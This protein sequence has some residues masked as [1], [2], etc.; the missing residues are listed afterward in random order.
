MPLP[1][2]KQSVCEERARA[3]MSP[4]LNS[5]NSS[6]FGMRNFHG[7]QAACIVANLDAAEHEGTSGFSFWLPGSYVI[8]LSPFLDLRRCC[9]WR[10]CLGHILSLD[11]ARGWLSS[12]SLPGV[13][14][15]L[16]GGQV[17]CVL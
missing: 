2:L 17:P 6:C 3:A 12:L 5:Q 14:I 10:F 1:G 11:H 16:S 9:L 15:V 7:N 4:T 13:F 8:V